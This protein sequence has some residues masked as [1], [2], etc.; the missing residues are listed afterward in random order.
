MNASEFQHLGGNLNVEYRHTEELRPYKGNAR[1]HSKKQIEQIANSIHAFGFT[2]PIITDGEGRIIAGHG[3]VLAAQRLGMRNVPTIRL[4]HFT[5]AQ[6]RAY[7]LADNKLAELA[8]WDMELL[9]IEF[10]GLLEIDM[11]FDLTLTGFEFAEI[12][13]VIQTHKPKPAENTHLDDVPLLS[14]RAVSRVG[15]LWKL[16]PHWLYCGDALDENSYKTVL[17]GARAD[18]VF[19]DPPYN[20]HISGHVC[21]AG[22]VQHPEFLMASGEMSKSQFTFFLTKIT[23]NLINFTADG[24]IHFICMDWRHMHELLLGAAAYE[25]FKNLCVWNKTN[26]G[27]GSLYRSK[28]E[29][30]FVFKNGKSAHV[31]NIELGRYGRYRT[32]VWDYAGV[33]TFKEDRM[34]EL[35]MHPTVKPVELVKDAILDCS[36]PKDLIL[37][38]FGGS[39]TSLIA[40]DIAGRVA[41]LIELDPKYI[42]CTIRRFECLTNQQAILSETGE[43]YSAVKN[44]REHENV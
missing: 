27:M 28:H 14:E 13:T 9:A 26:G 18:M 33:N 12:D 2:N 44:R 42:D 22:Q 34:D 21:G 36:R 4:E 19:A 10:S 32:N 7:T 3:R 8:G 6:K 20:V 35:R 25:E 24:S 23:E 15:D 43:N 11:D 30:V 40:A 17:K 31:N 39:G 41:H 37:D 29:L 16:G 5:E 38:P 1:T